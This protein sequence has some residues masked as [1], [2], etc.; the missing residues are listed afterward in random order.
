M[1]TIFCHLLMPLYHGGGEG[2]G[3]WRQMADKSM[4]I[5]SSRCRQEPLVVKDKDGRPQEDSLVMDC[6]VCGGNAPLG[7]L[8]GVGRSMGTCLPS[9]IPGFFSVY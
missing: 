2:R 5:L 4:V 3:C 6:C 9:F 1:L 8:G 7:G